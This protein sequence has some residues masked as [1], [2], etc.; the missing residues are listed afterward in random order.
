M[1]IT[2]PFARYYCRNQ[3]HRLWN[4]VILTAPHG[5]YLKVNAIREFFDGIIADQ[6]FVNVFVLKGQSAVAFFLKNPDDVFTVQIN[7]IDREEF[8]Y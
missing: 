7:G 4:R 1:H 3:N 5:E 6:F 2:E 8:K